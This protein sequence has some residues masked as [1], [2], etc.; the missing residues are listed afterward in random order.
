MKFKDNGI[1]D[2]SSWKALAPP[3]GGDKQWKEGRSALELARYMTHSYPYIPEEIEKFLLNF[4][5]PDAEFEWRAEY[6]TSFAS[7]GLGRGEGRNHD[8]FLKNSDIVIGIEGKADEPLGSQRVG[9][10]IKGAG[11]NKLHRINSMVQMLFGESA[12]NHKNIRYQLLTA[13]TAT[14]LEAKKHNIQ[15]AMFIIIVFKKRGCYQEN[16]I[17]KNNTDI[18]NFLTEI[19]AIPY[20]D[21]YLIPT[22]YGKENGIQLYFKHLEIQL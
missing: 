1:Y 10:A 22:C 12:E 21:C 3:M 20:R 13:A 5:A 8:A 4:T 17:Q 14:L 19:S 18:S 11:E 9:E 16:K 15:K 7:F 6:V 2:L